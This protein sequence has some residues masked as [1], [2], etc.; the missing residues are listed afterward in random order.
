MSEIFAIFEGRHVLRR[1]PLICLRNNVVFLRD[2]DDGGRSVTNDSERVVTALVPEFG[3]HCRI[4]YRDTMGCW[5]ELIH[6]HGQFR[7]WSHYQGWVPEGP[8][9][10][11]QH[12]V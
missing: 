12:G 7:G 5:T 10:R 3:L 6:E 2:A 1:H 4:V 8:P 9:T 11:E